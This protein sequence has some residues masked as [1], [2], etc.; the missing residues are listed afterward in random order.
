MSLVGDQAA[1]HREAGA[2]ADH[3]SR[4]VAHR[5]ANGARMEAVPVSRPLIHAVDEANRLGFE[6]REC[7]E[8]KPG[9]SAS[10]KNLES[11]VWARPTSTPVPA[12]P[13]L[14]DNCSGRLF[15]AAK[16]IVGASGQLRKQYRGGGAIGDLVERDIEIKA[17]NRPGVIELVLVA[18]ELRVLKAERRD[19][20]I[21][22]EVAAAGCIVQGPDEHAGP[23]N[24]WTNGLTEILR[25]RARFRSLHFDERILSSRSRRANVGWNDLC[26]GTVLSARIE[27]G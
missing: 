14:A 19:G 5:D 20:D 15:D 9:E 1:T 2:L 27:A 24:A 6:L 8:W 11:A 21:C 22:T 16:P 25:S 13:L 23:K 26:A 17:V 4:T 3:A 18:V 10:R 7:L 12:D